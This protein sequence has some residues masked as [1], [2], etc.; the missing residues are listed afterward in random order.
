VTDQSTDS[1]VKRRVR[2]HWG[3]RAA[4]FDEAPQHGIHSPEQRERWRTVLETW[5]PD[6][7]LGALDVGCGTGVLSLLLA[8]LGYRVTGVDIAPEMLERARMKARETD[9]SVAFLRGDAEALPVPD[10]AIELLT[11]RHLLWTLPNPT[12]AILEWQRV[13]EPGGRLLLVEGYWNHDE[14]WD[15]YEVVH[16]DL[17]MYDGR[18]P[19]ELCVDLSRQGLKRVEY[20]LLDDPTLW[21]REPRHEYYVVV[22][23][24]G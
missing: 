15:E 20:E 6:R 21:G 8:D 11:A 9:R 4:T 10:D 22:G 18:P 19:G 13:L 17:P 7:Q 3:S 1:A 24:V 12:D 2:A 5:T 14:P 16:D 23:S